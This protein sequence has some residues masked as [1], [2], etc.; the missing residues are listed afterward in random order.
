MNRADPFP[1]YGVVELLEPVGAYPAG[2]RGTV[3]EVFD[4]PRRGYLIEF[5]DARGMEDLLTLDHEAMRCA[6]RTVWRPGDP[7]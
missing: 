1:H 5:P 6:A 7:V 2:A 4:G 3:V